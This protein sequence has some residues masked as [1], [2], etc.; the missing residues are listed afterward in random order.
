MVSVSQNTNCR[1]GPGQAYKTLGA[2]LVGE[3]AEDVGRSADNQNW[4]IKN[5]DGAGECW[6]WGYYATITG[7]TANLPVITPPS[8]FD[9]SSNWTVFLGDN[10]FAFI[11]TMIVTIN[12]KNFSAVIDEGGGDMTNLKGTVSDDFLTVSGTWTNTIGGNGSF[13]FFALGD[14][15]FQGHDDQ[16][17]GW[18]GDRSGVVM[19]DPCYK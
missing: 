4:I 15:Q 11:D 3:Q 7:I 14:T 2:L 13:A 8:L 6:L 10:N 19:P 16:G 1:K 18:C 17:V 12:G 9:W 5:P